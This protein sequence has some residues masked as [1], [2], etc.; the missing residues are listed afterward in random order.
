MA[1]VLDEKICPND[2]MLVNAVAPVAL[3]QYLGVDGPRHYS[4]KPLLTSE[5]MCVDLSTHLI[6][7]RNERVQ[8]AEESAYQ[9]IAHPDFTAEASEGGAIV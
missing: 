2:A 4:W 7:Q 1:C 9:V 6:K 3:L 5:D 8:K